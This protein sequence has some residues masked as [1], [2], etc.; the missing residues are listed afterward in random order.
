MLVMRKEERFQTI[1]KE[2]IQLY[3]QEQNKISQC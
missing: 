1:K 2:S 3:R